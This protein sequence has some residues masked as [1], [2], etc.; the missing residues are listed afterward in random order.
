MSNQEKLYLVTLGGEAHTV[1]QSRAFE[2]ADQL[3]A[4]YGGVP[5]IVPAFDAGD[6]S[7]VHEA[8]NEAQAVQAAAYST[9]ETQTVDESA[10]ARIDAQQ[11]VLRNAGITGIG[12]KGEGGDG[13]Q[14]FANGTRMAE[15]GYAVQR[16]RK[17][18]HDAAMS[19][20]DAG[21]ALAATVRAEGRE[22]LTC[23]AREFAQALT[24]NGKI[25]AFGRTLSE[26]SIRGI[27]SRLESPALSYLLG[28][29]ARIMAEMS[30]PET[31]DDPDVV[32]RNVAA[33]RADRAKVAEILAHE[34]KRNP[35]KAF[36]LRT[37]KN[38]GDI[39][40]VVSPEYAPADAPEVLG[41]IL[42]K[43]PAD[44]KGTWS[45]DAL[46]TQWELRAMVWTPTPVEE[47]AVGEPFE[48]FASYQA[49]DNGTSRF[50]GGGGITIARCLNASTYVADGSTADR[51]HRGRI[52]YDIERMTE[53]A[54]AS[55]SILC[56]AWG[57][58]REKVIEIPA[59]VD[60]K[61]MTIDQAIPGLF[62]HMLKSR[63]LVGVLPGRTEN[64]VEALTRTYATE[65]RDPYRVVRADL[66]QAFTRHIQDQ[67][68]NVRRD[69]E[70]SV[71]DWL[72][73]NKPMRFDLLGA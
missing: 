14:Y 32:L 5:S 16:E 59:E 67:P 50:R 66:G 17:A 20:V 38:P 41:Q 43:M 47:Q 63:E 49:R 23:S 26:Q 46:S 11:A 22:D 62:R 58:N 7:T 37:R 56:Q 42:A 53:E 52:L 9:F 72:M 2:V 44:A 39:F 19:I 1:P 51:V 73:S 55:I 21:H 69:A 33:L 31:S 29:R 27:V 48:G 10:K 18:Q 60:H 24:V 6:T 13:D 36:K 15:E 8:A 68:A 35:D 54:L 70:M 30:K 57:T 71:S 64:H 65:R 61:P 34:C 3:V 40:A 4:K 12:Y 28:L 45:Y 25:Q